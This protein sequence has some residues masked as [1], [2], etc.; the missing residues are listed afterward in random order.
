MYLKFAKNANKEQIRTIINSD[1]SLQSSN[2][3][4]DNPV[5]NS[6]ILEAKKGKQISP[7]TINTY[8][9]KAEIVSAT[10]RLSGSSASA[11]IEENLLLR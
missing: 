5:I 8:K 11:V 2:V 3:N 10:P 1:S 4:L 6:A 9:A 7:A